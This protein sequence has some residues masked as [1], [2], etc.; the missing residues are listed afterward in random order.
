MF[1]IDPPKL[2][3]ITLNSHVPM[4]AGHRET[5]NRV[6]NSLQAREDEAAPTPDAPSLPEAG[7]QG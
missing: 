7:P 4:C 6:L 3:V 5:W 2:M 1:A